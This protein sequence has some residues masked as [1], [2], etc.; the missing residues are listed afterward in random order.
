MIK[1][2]ELWAKTEPFESIESHLLKTGLVCSVAINESSL[3]LVYNVLKENIEYINEQE[4]QNFLCYIVAM[5]DIGKAS[6]FFQMKNTEMADRL[7]L[8]GLNQDY[9][10]IFQHECQSEYYMSD[11]LRNKGFDRKF[12]E[13]TAKVIGLH[14]ERHSK[15]Q[16]IAI[17]LSPKVEIFW[18]NAVE[19]LEKNIFNTYIFNSKNIVNIKN[20]DVFFNFLQGLIIICDWVASSLS[21]YYLKDLDKIK[22]LDILK[23]YGFI[24]SKV[25]WK[26]NWKEIGYL[27]Y[28]RCQKE[29][30]Q[31]RPIQKW[32]EDFL[33][34]NNFDFLIIEAGTGEGKSSVG[35]YSA[36]QEM[37]ME[38]GFYLALPTKTM[39][40]SKYLELERILK[41]YNVHLTLLHGDRT[42]VEGVENN[43]KYIEEN[44]NIVDVSD[45]LITET[46]RGLLNKYLI[47]TIDQLLFSVLPNRYS[48]LRLIGL[49]GKTLILDEIHAYD[50]YTSSLISVLLTWC[51]ALNIK[52]ILMSATLTKGL[53]EQYL[54]SYIGKTVDLNEQSYPLITLVDVEDIKEIAIKQDKS[55]NIHLECKNILSNLEEQ[56]DNIK[57][58]YN[59]G[60]NIVVYK[61]TVSEAQELYKLC[62]KEGIKNILLCHSRFKLEDRGRIENEIL[63]Y[64]G[65][66]F[67]NR[68]QQFL[69]IAT[70]VLEAALDID[71][72]IGF[73]DIAPIDIIFQ[74]MGRVCRFNIEVGNRNKFFL[75]TSENNKYGV[76]K[77]V[78]PE[79]FLRNTEK[80]CVDRNIIN[81][82]L[83]F[84]EGIETVYRDIDFEDP[85]ILE[86]FIQNQTEKNIKQSMGINNAISSPNSKRYTKFKISNLLMDE[87]DN[88]AK[89]TR[90][91]LPSYNVLLLNDGEEKNY[92]FFDLSLEKYREL[93]KK[94][95]NI[96]AKYISPNIC[97]YGVGRLKNILIMYMKD[98]EYNSNGKV[99]CYR[100]SKEIGLEYIIER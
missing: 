93:M 18:R 41:P 40:N 91:F 64:F 47:G 38:D 31:L 44:N 61:N 92:N 72:D 90:L 45:F 16:G 39:V 34:S 97:D 2:E 96:N 56:C 69:V 74:R 62:K 22:I 32:T 33:K 1:I 60:S 53:K 65:K 23:K 71:F 59:M 36:F 5:H 84:R 57:E 83:N 87:T 49:A 75:F 77:L 35:F 82:P 25:N 100:Y 21:K 12:V 86:L 98:N 95:V 54:K 14:H 73:S 24:N 8:E 78:Y 55:R 3:Q 63:K 85:K 17:S 11:I 15:N 28:L 37:K 48:I 30:L 19:E 89:S 43:Y 94:V 6:P 27:E 7:E 79:L 80:Y 46:R 66:D 26:V 10:G 99:K 9:S 52:V 68:P 67:R 29:D 51:R 50:A 4:F 58:Y 70:Q 81:I 20:Y 88:K 13:Y 76:S 42:L